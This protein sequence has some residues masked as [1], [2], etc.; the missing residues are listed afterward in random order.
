MQN[1]PEFILEELA[2]LYKMREDLIANIQAQC[3]A[4]PTPIMQAIPLMLKSRDK[5]AYVHTGS[6]KTIINCS[7]LAIKDFAVPVGYH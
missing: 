6:R 4:A 7:S 3:H 1:M 2:Q 5:F